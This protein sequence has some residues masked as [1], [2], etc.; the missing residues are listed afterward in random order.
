MLFICTL[1]RSE[2]V[3]CQVQEPFDQLD[4]SGI[5]SDFFWPQ[6]FL[7]MRVPDPYSYTDTLNPFVAAD[8]FVRFDIACLDSTVYI[9]KVSK[10]RDNMVETS[11]ESGAY[12][13][14]I[15]DITY[16]DFV[17]SVFTDSLIYYIDGKYYD[18]PLRT[19][20]PYVEK[21][22]AILWCYTSRF[23][24][25]TMLFRLD[26][27]HYITNRGSLPDSILVDFGDGNGYRSI[28]LDEV[29]EIDFSNVEDRTEMRL[30]I[31]RTGIGTFRSLSKLREDREFNPCD[32]LTP[33]VDYPD[34]IA[35]LPEDFEITDPVGGGRAH[36]FVK[37]GNDNEFNKPFIFVEGID[38]GVDDDN[39]PINED[40]RHGTF[41]WCEFYSG[42]IDSNTDDAEDYRYN[43]LEKLPAALDELMANGYDLV[44]V[45]F[46]DG[47]ADMVLNSQLL[48]HAI[49]LCNEN[50]TGNEPLVIAG[51]SMGGQ[52]SRHALCTM[53]QNDVPH[54]CR[55]WISIDSPH[56]GA[57]ISLSLQRAIKFLAE[58]GSEGAQFKMDHL[59]GSVAAKQLLNYQVVE[60]GINDRNTWYSN[61]DDLGY[62]EKCRII[63][64]SNGNDLG[65][66]LDPSDH[67][68]DYTCGGTIEI[69]E[70]IT[71]SGTLFKML[72]DPL[73]GNTT[74]ASE[75]ND[76]G[77]FRK[78]FS[79]GDGFVPSELPNYDYSPGGTTGS[80]RDFALAINREFHSNLFTDAACSDVE[81]AVYRDEQSFIS[82]PSAL[83]LNNE[84]PYMIVADYFNNYPEQK[85]FDSYI[86]APLDEFGTHDNERHTEITDLNSAF[87]LNEVLRDDDYAQL[88]VIPESGNPTNA[89]F[90]YGLPGYHILHGPELNIESG[91]ELFINKDAQV[92]WGESGDDYTEA[93]SFMVYTLECE[94]VDIIIE[95]DGL[96]EI[97]D[98]GHPAEV[99]IHA[100][101]RI[102]IQSSG[103]LVVNDGGKLVIGKGAELHIHKKAKLIVEDGGIIIIETGGK[104]I[105][106]PDENV[107]ISLRGENAVLQFDGGELWIDENQELLIGQ[108][109]WMTGYVEIL[110]GTENVLHTKPGSVLKFLGTG[111][112]D[113]LLKMND[114][115]HLQNADFQDGSIELENCLVDL[116]N[117]GSIRTDLDVIAMNTTFRDET[118]GASQ[119]STAYISAWYDNA[120]FEA[121]VFEGV[122]IRTVD[123]HLTVGESDFIGP[124]TGITPIMGSYLLYGCSFDEAW[125]SSQDL[126]HVSRIINC[127]F[128]GADAQ[129]EDES[130]VEI[131]VSK[132]NFQNGETALF[133]FGGRLSVA[134]SFFGALE[135]AIYLEQCEL[136]M[137]L[138]DNNGNNIFNDVD[139][140][141]AL[142]VAIV[143]DIEKGANDFSGANEFIAM[144]TIDIPCPIT[145]ACTAVISADHNYWGGSITTPPASLFEVH[146]LGSCASQASCEIIF[147]G[148]NLMAPYEECPF[149]GH[150]RLSMSENGRLSLSPVPS[151]NAM[152]RNFDPNDPF[153]TTLN[154]DHIPLDSA[155]YFAWSQRE[156]ADSSGDDAMAIHLLHEIL[157]DSLDQGNFAIRKKMYKASTKMKSIMEKMFVDDALTIADNANAFQIPVDQYVDILNLMTDTALTDSTFRLQFALELNKGQLFRT[158]GKP[159]VAR[160][161]F[162]NLGDCE[163]DS[164]RQAILNHWLQAVD[165]E[166][167]LYQQYV[168]DESSP[169]SVIMDVNTE[170]YPPLL[171]YE[172]SDYYF[173]VWIDSPNEV[174]FVACGDD[175]MYRL[176]I[177]EGKYSVYPNPASG[178]VQIAGIEEGAVLQCT[179]L[180]MSGRT[181]I[182]QKQLTASSGTRIE[183]NN[184]APGQYILRIA[185]G[186]LVEDHIIVI[187]K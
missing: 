31:V 132:C 5:S 137:D 133:K 34:A 42:F 143:V 94:P 91:G 124:N 45:D 58:N 155:V 55:L 161:I 60:E 52:I 59:L 84:D 141:M 41:G 76:V 110:P 127:E 30:K 47:A 81:R 101:S 125:V 46:L 9:S 80:I 181:V 105:C 186:N 18:N 183:L 98:A 185:T 16:H 35:W 49:G 138:R 100:G 73:P 68:M 97:A 172:V 184:L 2:I 64:V 119:W 56:A 178:Y 164:S 140:I 27:E 116:T 36:L 103:E 6:T 74:G 33:V 95:P 79:V 122:Q 107:A 158:L 128:D 87:I 144:G 71:F 136:N 179:L 86:S 109:D 153:I 145:S 150:E 89:S 187:K 96:F 146:T 121:C 170:S 51:A 1:L 90:N 148:T 44:L 111:S 54:C 139:Y 85:H 14:A 88:S 23:K 99:F 75:I 162:A 154:F 113:L 115:A 43:M 177:S 72:M 40:F 151:N 70:Y 61:L 63:A 57:Y 126:D 130:L 129:V 69:N 83:G 134:C 174:T 160:E 106:D 48:Q 149:E 4:L 171:E 167:S 22:A 20:S 166:L 104:L 12:P 77:D 62:P 53:E 102:F 29:I 7:D 65:V 78:L 92:H 15:L 169:D 50:K 37:L 32:E 21:D 182:H 67:L 24:K 3:H 180:D 131:I 93:E 163:L 120:D 28:E 173:G 8:L 123:A 82:T 168:L 175:P 17:D 156:L 25:D 152:L 118:G 165:L 19:E 117:Y 108:D 112:H 11:I 135:S 114:Y 10:F 147:A 159:L 38:F 176:A 13:L 39:F 142:D 66:G 26:E 157:T